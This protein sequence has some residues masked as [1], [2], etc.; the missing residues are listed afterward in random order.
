[1]ARIT[2]FTCFSLRQVFGSTDFQDEKTFAKMLMAPFKFDPL[3]TRAGVVFFATDAEL[4]LGLSA[5]V[6]QVC[7]EA[8]VQER[9]YRSVYRSVSLCSVLFMPCSCP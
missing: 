4:V 8:C 3:F 1:M 7:T 9:V 5:D 6:T 2:H